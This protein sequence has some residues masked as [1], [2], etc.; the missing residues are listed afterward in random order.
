MPRFILLLL[1]LS[2]VLSCAYSQEPDSL[3]KSIHQLESEYYGKQKL[4]TS[5]I[6]LKD[7]TLP[8]PFET[9]I[10]KNIIKNVLGWHPYWASSSAPNLY[11]YNA[12]THIAYFSYEVDTATG[13]YSTIHDWNTTAL[14]STAHLNGTKVLL[15]VTN[16]GTS[17]NTRILS[18][19]TRQNTLISTLITLLKTR[20]GDGINFD[21]ESV[22]SSQRANLVKF[23]TKAS[24][25]IKKELPLAEIS[26]ATPAVDWN[27]SW[28][29]KALSNVCDYLV[30]MGYDYYYSGSSTAGPVAPLESENYNI[31]RSINTYLTAGVPP[32]KLMLGVPWYGYD[33]PV[34]TNIRKASSTGSATARIYTSAKTIAR[35][36]GYT[37]D[38]L[39]KVPWVSY[40]SSTTWRQLWYDDSV[41]LSL[42]YTLVN[43][44][45]MAGIGIWA[46]S[47]DGGSSEI[48][49]TIKRA[50]SPPDTVLKNMELNVYP[51]PVHGTS[52]IT[53]Y[54]ADKAN[55][56]LRII[57][58]TGKVCAI[59]Q[60]GEL[61]S[62]RYSY[63]I[64]STSFGQGIYMCVLKVNKSV[65]TKK[66]IIIRE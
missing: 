29:V 8:A 25:N 18:D 11:D 2:E 6:S 16:F 19:S 33:W 54:L 57:D 10:T 13:S 45:N 21:F 23:M 38:Q 24:N 44:K 59:L 12:L 4:A 27:G 1:F 39:T 30:I 9:G 28:D 42:K 26:M 17:R 34:T 48:W 51:N 53:F 14:I 61:D 56:S 7:I 49:R 35:T 22:G 5:E 15:T 55:V 46:L 31:T 58:V 43:S 36:N 40:Y 32:E 41:S 65:S 64:N 50:F 37:F 3:R 52:R 20:N 62:G 60:N 47:Y 63:D 66:I